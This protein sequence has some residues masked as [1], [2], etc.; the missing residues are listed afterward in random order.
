MRIKKVLFFNPPVGF[1]QRGEERCQANIEGSAA[2]SIRPPNNLGYMASVLRRIGI[3]PLIRDYPV[4][5]DRD[6][7]KDL[8]TFDPEM[9]VM[10]IT[11]ATIEDDLLYFKLAKEVKKDIITVAE[12]A[13]FITAPISSFDEDIYK[14]IDFAMYGESE[15]IID[16]LVIALNNDLDVSNVKGLIFKRGDSW[17]KTQPS[18]FIEH[19]DS[20]PFP[21][22]DLMRNELYINPD[23]GNPIATIQ[24][25]RGCP[26]S[27]IYCLTPIVSGKKIRKRSAE[28]IVDEVE[29]CIKNYGIHEFFFR[30]DTFTMDKDWVISVC[31]EIIRR[32]LKTKWVANSRVKPLDEETLV[33]MKKAGCYLVAFGV[34][35]G[36]N[37]SLKLMKKGT[38]VEDAV[39]AVNMAK[40]VVLKTYCFFMLGFPWEKEEDIKKTI[41]F[42]KT[43][44]CDFSEFHIAIP[45]YGTE[46]FKLV[47]REG[48]L[49]GDITGHNY[50]TNPVIG[51]KYLTREEVIRLRKKALISFYL[52][53]T[54]M[55]RMLAGLKSY[56]EL[57]NYI[58]YGL[59]LLSS[60]IKTKP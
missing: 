30:A 6:F 34:E 3:V 60:L 2:I 23:T 49:K 4:E 41:D 32:N 28:N 7:V 58:T 9:I 37:E 54:Y 44:P 43:L 38:T 18:P 59:R 50:F 40:R 20:L 15:A 21:A 8:K 53:P 26:A 42:S 11:T 27:C 1:Y 10:S 17:I 55:I 45:Y 46:L 12:G 39:R 5:R 35:S 16:K 31:K 48:L 57:V 29:E 19:L 51:T 25:S 36:S 33:W 13:H 52:R 24:T 47:K 22:R 14:Y 56:K